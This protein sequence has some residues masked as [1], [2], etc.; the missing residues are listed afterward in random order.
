MNKSPETDNPRVTVTLKALVDLA[1]PAGMLSLGHANI[2]AAQSGNYLSHL[3]GRGMAF[4]ET[5]LYQPGD[6]VRRIDWRVTARTDKPHSKIFKEERE[7][8]MFIAVDYRATMV[9]A[10][11][12]VFKSVQAARLAGLLAW[13][14]LKQGDRIG[15]QIFSD[16]GCQELK[17][18]TG[19]PALLRFLNALVN[20]DYN[21]AAV[22]NLAQPLARLLHH[23]RPGSRVYILSD[24]RGMNSAA[25][26]HLANLARHC[27]VVLV[28][29]AD[30]LESSL[31]T[32]GR[33]RF[34]DG[35]RDILIDSGDKQRL[36]AYRQ[37]FQDRQQYLQKLGNKL[38]LMLIPCTTQQ[39]PLDAL[40]GT[41]ARPAA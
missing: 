9:F 29:I 19:K 15:G 30:P 25:E 13:A 28:H 6:D 10:T 22:V 20:P 37:R 24:F 1:K 17:P 14:A 5:R 34:T 38:R 27:E 26:N 21:G 2:R 4:D 16:A 18:Q 40:N 39:A 36:Q 7:R 12:G 31:P 23:A 11:R 3:K 32:Q 8:P 33:Y 35:L 41:R